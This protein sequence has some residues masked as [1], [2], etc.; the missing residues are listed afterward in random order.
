LFNYLNFS[1][2]IITFVG[3]LALGFTLGIITTMQVAHAQTPTVINPENPTSG[4]KFLD[5]KAYIFTVPPVEV[6]QQQTTSNN[7]LS[8]ILPA[9]LGS[10]GAFISGK[11]LSDKKTKKVSD[12]V[13]DVVLPETVKIKENT[14]ELA[15]VTYNM[16]PEAAAKIEDAPSVKV[17]TLA[18]DASKFAEKAA[19]TSLP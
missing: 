6:Q 8:S 3:G 1:L 11:V 17:T 9:L 4:L 7:D 10:A 19:K 12:V 16:N 5:Q 18:D 14:K 2:I 13:Q 15:R